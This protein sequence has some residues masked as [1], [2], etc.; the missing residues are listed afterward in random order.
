MSSLG[1]GV[2]RALDELRALRVSKRRA[3][4]QIMIN[5]VAL[6]ISSYGNPAAVKSSRLNSP[7]IFATSRSPF[8]NPR[9]KSLPNA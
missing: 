2:W 1:D 8:P 5:V 6:P 9:L 3:S 7:K 4:S